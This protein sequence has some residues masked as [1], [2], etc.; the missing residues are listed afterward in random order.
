MTVDKHIKVRFNIIVN[1]N[2]F[3]V[4]AVKFL[5]DNNVKGNILVPFD[6]GEYAIWKLYPDNRV[7]IDGRFDTVYPIDVIKD[8]LMGQVR[9]MHGMPLLKN[10]QQI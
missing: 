2:I 6:W 3:P 9:E 4:Y 5:K 8:Y 1:P 7:S 10:I